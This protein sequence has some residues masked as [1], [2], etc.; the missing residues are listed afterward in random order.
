MCR[1]RITG[2]GFWKMKSRI[3]KAAAA[4]RV[5]NS[6]RWKRGGG[7]GFC[8]EW[9]RVLKEKR[10]SDFGWDRARKVSSRARLVASVLVRRRGVLVAAVGLST[11]GM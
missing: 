11:A 2:H 7:R 10:V 6:G 1:E 4:W 8:A 3:L 5:T 9:Q